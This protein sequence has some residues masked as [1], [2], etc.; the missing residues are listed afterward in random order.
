MP[1]TDQFHW[2]Q[3]TLNVVFAASSVFLLASV[4]VMM[5]QDQ[6]DEWK[7]YQRTNFKLDATVRRADLAA[8]ESPEYKAQVE[9][10]DKQVAEAAAALGARKAENPELFSGQGSLQ[11]KV[12]NLEINLKFKNSDR[13]EARAQYDLAVRDG[14][15][16]TEMNARFKGFQEKQALCDSAKVELDAAKDL[17]AAR[18]AEVKTITSDYDGFVAAREKVSFEAERVRAAV[19]KVEPSNLVSSWKRAM[20]ELPIIDGFNSH[21][22]IV[23]DWMP[24]LKQTLGMAE[25]ARFDRCRSCHQNIDKTSGNGG[26][27]F[28][29][30]HPTSDDI[31]GWVSEKKFPQ[32]YS[33][34]PNTDLYCTSSSPHPVAKF[35]CT[36]CHDGQGSGT[37]F[38]NAEHT[39]N[40]PQISHEWHGEYGF[41]PNHF[42]EYPMQPSRFA[43]STCIKC[44]HSVTE[45]G[46][47]PKFG[48]S[49]PKV[50]RGYQLIQK[51]GCYGCHEMYG[52]DGG[53]SIGPDMRLEPRRKPK[54]RGSLLIQR[55]WLAS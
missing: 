12:D 43:E 44:H 28:P 50:F 51:Y 15:P 10:L 52:F 3:K 31:A 53:V 45:L 13:D 5:K 4:I 7:V 39:P 40:D 14:L 11:R 41:H 17:L 49:A 35:G 23:Q 6:A 25:I 27:A 47:N 1:A 54:R 19:E 36:I 55:R 20:M 30:G 34:H 21:L 38:G 37:S 42:W 26:P 46:V 9:E 8:I 18:T 29:A 16:E 22:R 48:A 32:P 33:T 2:N 24:K